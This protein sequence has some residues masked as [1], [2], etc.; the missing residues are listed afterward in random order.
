MQNGPEKYL[1]NG[2]PKNHKNFTECVKYYLPKTRLTYTT[3]IC[4]NKLQIITLRVW[5]ECEHKVLR[6][7][8]TRVDIYY[9]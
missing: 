4:C 5:E 6:V 3:T 2:I 1:K 7:P 9:L 8:Y